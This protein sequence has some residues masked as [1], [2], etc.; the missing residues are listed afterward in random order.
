MTSVNLPATEIKTPSLSSQGIQAYNPPTCD[1][2]CAVNKLIMM[3]N[4]QAA[5]NNAFA[6]GGKNRKRGGATITVPKISN[7][8]SSDPANQGSIK[9]NTNLSQSIANAQYDNCVNGNCP[10]I[11]TKL[12]GGK[13]TLKKY[14]SRKNSHKRRL[15]QKKRKT[16]KK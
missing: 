12:F 9:V 2:N 8:P 11:E 14:K 15:L 7:G 1:H 10:A 5:H 16:I 3:N 13:R 4:K 6:K